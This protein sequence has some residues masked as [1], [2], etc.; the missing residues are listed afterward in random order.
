MFWCLN[1]TWWVGCPL[2]CSWVNKSCPLFSIEDR[3]IDGGRSLYDEQS[4]F[5]HLAL[6]IVW[7]LMSTTKIKSNKGHG[8]KETLTGM[9]QGSYSGPWVYPVT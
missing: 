7:P 9:K 6:K 4:C 5:P 8:S 3:R 1:V 2:Y